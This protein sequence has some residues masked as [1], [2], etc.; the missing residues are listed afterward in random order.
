MAREIVLEKTVNKK[1]LY[2]KTAL[3]KFSPN[4]VMQFIS[5]FNV[6]ER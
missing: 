2:F 4:M 1:Y 5:F 6:E 3:V